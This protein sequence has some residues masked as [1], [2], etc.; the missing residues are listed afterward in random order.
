[1]KYLKHFENKS[2][3]YSEISQIDYVTLKKMA[4]D[5]EESNITKIMPDSGPK[6]RYIILD[7]QYPKHIW[8]GPGFGDRSAYIHQCKDEYFTISV[9]YATHG[10]Y[11][12][13]DQIDGVLQL[14]KD[15]RIK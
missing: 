8:I 13:C 2:E 9:F 15:K 3:Y 7:R 11:Y 5:I 14:L 4:I 12:K 10:E 6:H 1:M